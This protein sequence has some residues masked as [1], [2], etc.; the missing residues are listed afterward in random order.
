M[1]H[2]QKPDFFFRAK[3]TSPFISAEASVQSTAGSRGVRISGSNAGYTMFRGSVKS[4]GYPLYSPVSPPLPL[5]CVTMCHHISTG[6]YLRIQNTRCYN[7]T[8]LYFLQ[9]YETVFLAV[10]RWKGKIWMVFG[11]EPFRVRWT[12]TLGQ[13]LC[14]PCSVTKLEEPCSLSKFPNGPYIYFPNILK[15]QKRRS[16]DMSV[17]VKPG[18]HTNIKHELRFLPQYHTSYKYG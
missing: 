15:F 1:A 7:H 9:P 14:V 8:K 2:T 6:L 13:A 3:R 17:W 4:T 16:L 11:L 10:E 18:P 12:L 5:P